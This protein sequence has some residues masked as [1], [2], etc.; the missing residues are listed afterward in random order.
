MK[1][2]LLSALTVGAVAFTGCDNIKKTQNLDEA[3]DATAD[4]AVVF[5]TDREYFDTTRTMLPT[6]TLPE[7]KTTATEVRGDADYQVYSLDETVLFDVDK[8]AIRPQ[9]AASLDE[10]IASVKQRYAG[11]EI[12]VMGYTDSTAS[13]SYNRDLARERAESVKNYMTKT[14][15]ISADDIT[16]ESF[17][18]RKPVATNATP[19]GRQKNRRVEIVVKTH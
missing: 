16:T 15:K 2:L 13:A 9:A 10:V 14:G 7:I 11:K 8:A 18:Q 1:T 6:V 5:R 12:M 4:T 17:G 3:S 19:E